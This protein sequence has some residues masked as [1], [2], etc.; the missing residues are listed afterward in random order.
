MLRKILKKRERN[1]ERNY[2]G[3]RSEGGSELEEVTP[4]GKGLGS[5]PG[6]EGEQ[7]SGEGRGGESS[8]VEPVVSKSLA[9]RGMEKVRMA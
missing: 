6:P 3:W 4:L 8:Q 7:D 2:P 1:E 5:E 9:F